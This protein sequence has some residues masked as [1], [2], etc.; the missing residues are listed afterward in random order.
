MI[1]GMIHIMKEFLKNNWFKL[2]IIFCLLLATFSFVYYLIIS[3]SKN[4]IPIENEDSRSSKDLTK[5]VDS[6]YPDIINDYLGSHEGIVLQDFGQPRSKGD[7]IGFIDDSFWSENHVFYSYPLNGGSITF[8]LDKQTGNTSYIEINLSKDS[9]IKINVPALGDKGDGT[10]PIILGES[11]FG[12]IFDKN[13]SGDALKNVETYQGGSA[14]NHYTNLDFYFGKYGE[15]HE[16]TFGVPGLYD[17]RINVN[18]MV[19]KDIKPTKLR[20]R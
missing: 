9:D 3:V 10:K 12:D 19:L 5:V 7:A 8:Y 6:L 4:N 18:Y 2:I 17:E 16:F 1:Y 13:K 20:I 11:T 15:Y 14:G